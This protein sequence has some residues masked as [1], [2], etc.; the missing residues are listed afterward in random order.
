MTRTQ[1]PRYVADVPLVLPARIHIEHLQLRDILQPS[2]TK[3][4]LLYLNHL[5]ID[6]IDFEDPKS[7]AATFCSLDFRANCLVTGHGLLAA[8]GQFSELAIRPLSAASTPAGANVSTST[9]SSS[10]QRQPTPWLLRTPTGGSINNS[11]AIYPDP[12]SIAENKRAMISE[13]SGRSAKALKK[14]AS[15]SPVPLRGEL[16]EGMWLRDEPHGGTQSIS[17]PSSR[18]MSSVEDDSDAESL[19]AAYGFE[20]KYA[21]PSCYPAGDRL[22]S[23]TESKSKSKKEVDCKSLSGPGDRRRMMC[24]SAMSTSNVRVYCCN[25]DRSLKVYKL[26]PPSGAS[27]SPALESGLPGLTRSHTLDFPT[28]VNHCSFSP[29]GQTLLAVGDT[30]HVFLYHR[31]PSTGAFSHITTYSASS[32]ASF[33]TSWHPD[34]TK[35]AVASQDGVVSVWD[36][37]SSKKL[38]E[39]KT[40]QDANM[41]VNLGGLNGANGAARVVKFSP[42]GR[43]LAFTEHRLYFHVYDTLTYSRGQRIRIPTSLDEDSIETVEVAGGRD[44][45]GAT[46]ATPLLSNFPESRERRTGLLESR[47]LSSLYGQGRSSS[48]AEGLFGSARRETESLTSSLRLPSLGDSSSSLHAAS[49]AGGVGN[50]SSPATGANESAVNALREAQRSLMAVRERIAARSRQDPSFTSGAGTASGVGISGPFDPFIADAGFSMP[51]L[52]PNFSDGEQDIA[53]IRRESRPDASGQESGSS[54]LRS[55]NPRTEADRTRLRLEAQPHDSDDDEEIEGPISDYIRRRRNLSRFLPRP[56]DG[57]GSVSTP[58]TRMRRWFPDGRFGDDP[59]A[60]G[61]GEGRPQTAS[62]LFESSLAE[63]LDD[64]TLHVGVAE[65]PDSTNDDPDGETIGGG[66][67]EDAEEEEGVIF[68]DDYPPEGGPTGADSITRRLPPLIPSTARAEDRSVGRPLRRAR[69]A[70]TQAT[71]RIPPTL[72]VRQESA[73]AGEHPQQQDQQ[74]GPPRPRW[75]MTRERAG[76]IERAGSGTTATSSPFGPFFP[77]A[78]TTTAAAAPTATTGTSTTASRNLTA[79]PTSTAA[80]PSSDPDSDCEEEEQEEEADTGGASRRRTEE[81]SEDLLTRLLYPSTVGASAGGSGIASGPRRGAGVNAGI[82]PDEQ[83]LNISG[84]TWDP[85]GDYLYVSS[86]RCVCRWAVLRPGEG[87]DLVGGWEKGEVR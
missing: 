42:C 46:S 61:G 2:S 81:D 10:Q 20:R 56:D 37:R 15:S 74:A 71:L 48:F 59:D 32:D 23:R 36:V 66:N 18:P 69:E 28:A 12:V 54:P 40:S 9:T 38:A 60:S 8:G 51:G 1:E 45:G 43:F 62:E 11:V 55:S 25:N 39:L 78:N 84:L 80:L 7:P 87:G 22:R 79:A 73:N 14:E 19:A 17:G 31:H 83:W 63:I 82:V 47:L 35:F 49:P 33:S 30:P 67:A 86:E 72:R 64:G 27:S 13:S 26:R 6:E 85:D 16:A 41:M 44:L 75:P 65:E 4:K 3:G 58:A 76:E 52:A 68:I 77:P 50:S 21:G 5:K 24:Y 29:D 70:S 53:A 57:T 34:G